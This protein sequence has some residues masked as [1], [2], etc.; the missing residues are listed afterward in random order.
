MAFS[1]G[2]VPTAKALAMIGAA[3]VLMAAGFICLVLA[4]RSAEMSALAPFRYATILWAIVI[5]MVG[6][7]EIPDALAVL[8]IAIVIVAGLATFMRERRLVRSRRT[9]GTA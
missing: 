6:W 4:M 9:A 5:G 2:A 3:G 1:P 8:G 7:G